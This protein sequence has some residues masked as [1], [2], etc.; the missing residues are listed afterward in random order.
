M[1]LYGAPIWAEEAN[2]STKITSRARA[3]QRKIAIRVISGYRTVSQE[4]TLILARN[5]PLE[6]QAAKWKVYTRKTCMEKENIM[7]TDRGMSVI[8]KQEQERMLKKW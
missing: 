1:L 6:L 8:R 5:P 7:I 4:V 2:E 3:V